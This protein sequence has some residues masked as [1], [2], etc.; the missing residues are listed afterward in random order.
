MAKKS[1]KLTLDKSNI[2]SMN[3]LRTADIECCSGAL[4]VTGGEGDMILSAGER[5]R[6][7]V[8]GKLIIEGRAERSSICIG[9]F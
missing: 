2:M 5:K 7:R 9:H 6:I 8:D 1:L 4:W 3:G